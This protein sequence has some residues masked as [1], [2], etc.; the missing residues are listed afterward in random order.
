MFTDDT[1]PLFTFFKVCCSIAATQ[2]LKA[3]EKQTDPQFES[4]PG[5]LPKNDVPKSSIL[6]TN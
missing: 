4:Q 5:Q 6:G 3:G 1:S 2:R